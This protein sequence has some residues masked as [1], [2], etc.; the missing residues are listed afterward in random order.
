MA[1]CKTYINAAWKANSKTRDTGACNARERIGDDVSRRTREMLAIASEI[2]NKE[3][4]VERAKY[5]AERERH[6]SRC[7]GIFPRCFTCAA[8]RKD[9]TPF[10]AYRTVFLTGK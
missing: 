8:Y 2:M 3:A 1:L 10:L 4:S 6:T 5:P 7:N 9:K